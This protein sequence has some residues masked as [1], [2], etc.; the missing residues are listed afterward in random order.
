MSDLARAIETIRAAML[1]DPGYAIGWHA[2][3]AV[4]LTDEGVPHERAQ[5]QARGFM[6]RTFGVRDYEPS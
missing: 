3:L 2:N 4:M 6:L 1:V 5:E